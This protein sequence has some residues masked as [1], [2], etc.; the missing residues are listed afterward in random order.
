[1]KKVEVDVIG[2]SEEEEKKLKE[3]NVS[4]VPVSEENLAK[5]PMQIIDG[6]HPPNPE[7]LAYMKKIES[8]FNQPTEKEN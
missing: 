3:W 1:M 5:F 6:N 8:F 4:F 2:F 7:Q